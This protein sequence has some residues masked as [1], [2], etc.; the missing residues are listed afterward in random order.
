[1]SQLFIR[2]LCMPNRVKCFSTSRSY[3]PVDSGISRSLFPVICCTTHSK[4]VG[5]RMSHPESKL[6]VRLDI[7][8]RNEIRRL[9]MIK[10]SE[11]NRLMGR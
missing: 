10:L 2:S 3:M 9:R 5:S 1:M 11:L 8:R 4:L 6:M 7:I